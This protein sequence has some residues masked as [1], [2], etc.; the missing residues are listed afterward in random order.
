MAVVNNRD[1]HVV[2]FANNDRPA[3]GPWKRHVITTKCP[4][5]YD[6]VLADLDGD[7]D[8]DV[9]VAGYAS[10]RITW[11]ENPGKGGWDREWTEHLIDDKMS[12]ART[13]R[14]PSAVQQTAYPRASTASG[15]SESSRLAQ[16]RRR[17]SAR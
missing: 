2:W 10:G 7:G 17:P 4:R 13:I 3:A 11:Y 1:G 5:A 12:E 6:V 8:L 9:A 15:L 16:T 14:A